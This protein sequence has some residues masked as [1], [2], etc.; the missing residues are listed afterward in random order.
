MN[1]P[2]RVTRRPGHSIAG[3]L[4][5]AAFVL[6]WALGAP[7][8]GAEP[9]PPGQAA[10]AEAAPHLQSAVLAKPGDLQR[11]I[12]AR[13]GAAPDLALPPQAVLPGAAADLPALRPLA[14]AAHLPARG[15]HRPETRAPPAA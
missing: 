8:R 5:L 10:L 12:E 1:K 15:W 14:A 2:A 11:R 4:A 6:V 13:D 9:L 3:W 7:I